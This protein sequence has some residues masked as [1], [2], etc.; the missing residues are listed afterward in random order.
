MILLWG[1]TLYLYN[2]FTNLANR[3][4]TT[5]F[6]LGLILFGRH[7]TT[8]YFNNNGLLLYLWPTLLFT[9]GHLIFGRHKATK[10]FNNGLYSWSTHYWQLFFSWGV[11]VVIFTRLFILFE[12]LIWHYLLLD[13]LSIYGRG[14]FVQWFCNIWSIVL[15]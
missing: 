14:I 9:Y 11:Y 4:W 6:T 15:P 10:Y 1:K 5:Y 8:K 3:K 7:K 2:N 12:H 13:I